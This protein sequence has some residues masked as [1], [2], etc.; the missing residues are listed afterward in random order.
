MSKIHIALSFFL[1]QIQARF[2][3]FCGTENECLWYHLHVFHSE[4]QHEHRCYFSFKIQI[5][6]QIVW[7]KQNK[8]VSISVNCVWTVKMLCSTNSTSNNEPNTEQIDMCLVCMRCIVGI[9]RWI[10]VW[11]ID[12]YSLR[13]FR[14][15]RQHFDSTP[16]SKITLHFLVKFGWPLWSSLFCI[17]PIITGP[18][19]WSSLTIPKRCR[20]FFL[21]DDFNH[22]Q[23]FWWNIIDSIQHF[24]REIQL[25]LN[26]SEFRP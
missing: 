5:I 4:C 12:D 7:Q 20:N 22:L 18:G 23:W 6:T 9:K 19:L 16:F 13:V 14:C 26:D 1:G 3:I 21:N 2:H 10:S 25:D 17:T 24:E 15:L 11:K 8:L